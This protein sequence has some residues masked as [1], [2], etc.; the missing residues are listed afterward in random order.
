MLPQRD[1]LSDMSRELSPQNEQYL[2]SVVAGGLFPTEQA[3]LDAA[4]QALREKTERVVEVPE[5]HVKLIE[6][7]LISASAGRKRELGEAD[8]ERL[9]QRA[10]EVAARNQAHKS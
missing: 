3:A 5:E 8:W 10:D 1:T 7:A 4:I 6:E 2:A 9:R